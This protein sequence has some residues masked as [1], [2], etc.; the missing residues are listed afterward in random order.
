MARVPAP[1]GRGGEGSPGAVHPTQ[2]YI[3]NLAVRREARRRGV[4]RRLLQASETLCA[5][6]GF[7]VAQGGRLARHRWRAGGGLIALA[8]WPAIC[9]LTDVV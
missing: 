7:P 9:I 6:W 1:G 4:A 8:H 2:F 5:R 3:S